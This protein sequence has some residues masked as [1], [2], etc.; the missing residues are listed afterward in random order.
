ML[1][2]TKFLWIGAIA[3]ALLTL[4]GGLLLERA[5]SRALEQGLEEDLRTIRDSNVGA[6]QEWMH[7]QEQTASLTAAEAGA[8]EAILE[9]IKVSRGNVGSKELFA[10]PSQSR[11][12][13]LVAPTLKHWEF[14][15]YVVVA[16]GRIVGALQ[17]SAV[18]QKVNPERLG[19]LKKLNAG[20]SILTRPLPGNTKGES[21]AMWVASPVRD[22]KGDVVGALAFRIDPHK[23]FTRILK[24]AQFGGSGETYAFDRTGLML[25]S[26]RFDK[27]LHK[28]GILEEGHESLLTIKIREPLEENTKKGSQ[29]GREGPLTAAVHSAA[30]GNTAVNIDGYLDYRGV[31]VVGAW[32]WLPN[33]S[34]GIVTELDKE[35]AYISVEVIRTT[36]RLL[37]AFLLLASLSIVGGSR[38]ISRLSKKA[39]E[40]QILGQYTL[41]KK[42]GQGGM[43]A[44]YKARHALLRRPTAIKMIRPDSVDER[45]LKRFEREVQAT[46]QLCHP[47]TIAIYDYGRSAG[48]VFYYAMEYLDGIDLQDLVRAEGGQP[49]GRV[50]EILKQTLRSLAEAHSAGMVHRDIKPPNIMLCRRG[51]IADMVKVLDFGLVKK[52]DD[53]SE[54]TIQNSLTGTPHY[55][56][57]ECVMDP[58]TVDSRT[59]LY[60]LGVVGFFLLTGRQLFDG[61]NA[62]SVL[63]KQMTDPPERPSIYTLTPVLPELEELLLHC[64]EKDAKDRPKTAKDVIDRLNNLPL[65]LEERWTETLAEAWWQDSAERFSRSSGRPLTGAST[66]EIDLLARTPQKPRLKA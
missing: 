8:R 3:F 60:A 53:T 21:P 40:N 14:D 13:T 55:M 25:S 33:Y 15:A 46:A 31:E 41:E 59:D 10:H 32:T 19:V 52:L 4:L 2:Y 23:S 38:F 22:D 6:L 63:T 64:L 57:P 45:T 56:A 11:L 35:E 65:P 34:M 30:Q 17:E 48:G 43:G 9:M 47:N 16:D 49:Q 37:V 54:F 1:K 12:H 26:S 58:D 44:V 51:G 18:Y 5:V 39:E 20:Q 62:M 28:L 50:I 36:T 29:P 24:T 61:P 27:Q 66:V 42:L 7:A